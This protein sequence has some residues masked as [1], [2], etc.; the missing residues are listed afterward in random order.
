MNTK[1]TFFHSRPIF[2]T[3]LA[4]LLALS[5]TKFVFDG[6]VCYIVF[7]CLILAAFVGLSIWTKSY[8]ILAVVLAVFAFG[9]GWWFLGVSNFQGKV[10]EGE[11]QVVAR[12]SDDMTTYYNNVSVVAKDVKINGKSEGN[13]SLYIK[14]GAGKV[15][16]GDIITFVAQV[17]NAQLFDGEKFNSYY[18]RDHTPYAATI[19]DFV[20]Q[21]NSLS[22]IEQFRLKTKSVLIEN[23]GQEQGA[24][25]YAILFGDR[26]DINSDIFADFQSAG[27]VHLLAVSGLHISFLLALIA[28]ILKKC[29]V[30]GFWNFLVCLLLL[31]LYAYACNFSPSILRA[32]IMGLALTLSV[33]TGKWYDGLNALGLAGTLILLIFPLFSLDLGFLMSFFCVLAIFTLSPWLTKFLSQIFPKPIAAALGLSLGVQVGVLPFMAQMGTIFN[34]LTVFANLVIIPIFSLAYPILFVGAILSIIMPFCGFLLKISGFG[35]EIIHKIAIFFGK[36]SLIFS[37]NP[38]NIFVVASVFVLCFLSSRYFL[39]NKKEK[40]VCC[41]L[42]SVLSVVLMLCL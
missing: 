16:E 5:T 11:C 4:F 23:M 31:G 39:A 40:I 19:S 22:A 2:Y 38:I 25:G 8:K 15:K 29:H 32:G 28:F 35:L 30:R 14:G 34:I 20:L 12:L 33:Q 26:S 17:E 21:G 36:T 7:D 9:I 27:I 41:S 13:I 3:F 10:F 1:R 24:L 42:L 37:L 18:Y 6:N